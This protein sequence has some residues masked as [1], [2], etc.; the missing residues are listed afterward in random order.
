M[1]KII[2]LE[3]IY[4]FLCLA[5]IVSSKLIDYPSWLRSTFYLTLF[6]FLT[7]KMIIAVWKKRQHN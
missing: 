1:K 3:Y 5:F 6:A 2:I 4:L 7:V